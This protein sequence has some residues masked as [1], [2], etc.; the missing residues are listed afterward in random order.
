MGRRHDESA[1]LEHAAKTDDDPLEENIDDPSV[2]PDDDLISNPAP[3][4]S[5][6]YIDFEIA[7]IRPLGL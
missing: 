3:P 1:E 7:R 4:T 2:T 6:E 5:A